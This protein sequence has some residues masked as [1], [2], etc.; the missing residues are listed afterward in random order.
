MTFDDYAESCAKRDAAIVTVA[1][2]ADEN[3][4]GWTMR[5]GE[6]LRAYASQHR[7]FIAEECAAFAYSEGLKKEGIDTR[8]WGKVYRDAKKAGVLR[9]KGFGV[10]KNRNLSPTVLW[11]SSVYGRTA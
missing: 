7:E 1:A 6:L 2:H 9:K 10:S 4:D 3:V 8:A 11:E 5:A